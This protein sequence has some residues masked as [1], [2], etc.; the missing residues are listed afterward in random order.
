[1][2]S[3]ALYD[4][5]NY[6]W[7]IMA[8][9][10]YLFFLGRVEEALDWFYRAR[11]IFDKQDLIEELAHTYTDLGTAMRVL[12]QVEFIQNSFKSLP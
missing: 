10:R 5:R 8:I 9:G 1:M 11:D 4:L 3:Y 12:D 7:L 6:G 2:T